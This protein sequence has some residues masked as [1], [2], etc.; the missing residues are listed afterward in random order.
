MI[1]DCGSKEQLMVEQEFKNK[2]VHIRLDCMGC[3]KFLRYLPQSN[4]N[5]DDFVMPFGKHK[6]KNIKDV[7]SDYLQWIYEKSDLSEN[8]KKRAKSNLQNRTALKK[9]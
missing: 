5:N 8:I 2:T 7:P 4:V 6:G 1:C 9:D 3:G